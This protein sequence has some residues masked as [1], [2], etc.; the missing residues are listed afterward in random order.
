MLDGIMISAGILF[1]IVARY[2]YVHSYD[3]SCC[4]GEIDWLNLTA[5]ILFDC[6]SVTLIK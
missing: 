5:S 2:F 6:A 4:D 3:E 1:G